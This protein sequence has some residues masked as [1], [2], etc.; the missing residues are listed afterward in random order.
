MV[1]TIEAMK[2]KMST[3]VIGAVTYTTVA[4]HISTVVSELPEYL[5][6]NRNVSGVGI[7]ELVHRVVQAL[8]MESLMLITPFTQGTTQNG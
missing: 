6:R 4:N 2:T 8:T 5:A 7:Q 3:E 1:K